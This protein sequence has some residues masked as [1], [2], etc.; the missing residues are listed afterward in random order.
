MKEDIGKMRFVKKQTGYT[1]F[2]RYKVKNKRKR[3][4]GGLFSR[5][6]TGRLCVAS[7]GKS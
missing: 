3:Q 1:S 2:Y 4:A 7:Q 6:E 5:K